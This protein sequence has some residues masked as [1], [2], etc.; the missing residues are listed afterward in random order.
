MSRDAGSLQYADLPKLLEAANLQTDRAFVHKCI[1]VRH[2]AFLSADPE[3]RA[4]RDFLLQAVH[5]NWRTLQSLGCR[6]LKRTISGPLDT[7]IVFSE[8][9]FTHC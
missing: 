5:D 9:Q 2:E 3:L 8:I 4:D 1:A 6:H 7:V